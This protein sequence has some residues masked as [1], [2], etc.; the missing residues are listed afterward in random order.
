MSATASSSAVRFP[1]SVAGGA[2][3]SATP[4]RPSRVTRSPVLPISTVSVAFTVGSACGS[5][6]RRHDFAGE[7]LHRAHDLRVLEVA[8]PEAAVEVRDADQLA[9][10][11]DLADAG[12]RST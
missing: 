11:V 3:E 6:E 1:G 8:E 4:P 10:P 7:Q 5:P 9:D 2:P 12:V